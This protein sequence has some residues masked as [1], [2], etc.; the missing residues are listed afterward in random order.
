MLVFISIA[1]CS[2]VAHRNASDFPILIFYLASCL[3]SLMSSSSFLWV[4]ILF[5]LF[6]VSCDRTDVGPATPFDRKWT[7]GGPAFKTRIS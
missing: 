6:L 1:D 4:H 7:F 2:L 3:N 5:A